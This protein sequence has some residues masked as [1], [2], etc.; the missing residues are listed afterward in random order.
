MELTGEWKHPEA[1]VECG[2]L[3]N[4]LENPEIRIF[5]C[6]TYLHYTDDHPSKP[7]DV[8]SGFSDYIEAHIPKSSFLDL[9]RDLSDN[10]SPYSFTLPKYQ[11]LAESFMQLGVG[12]P[13]H[14]ILYS[15]NGM[16]WATRIWWMLYVVGYPKV[17]VLNGGFAEWKRLSLPIEKSSCHFDRAN[18]K[19]N[20]NKEIFVGKTR[21]LQS[22]GDKSS[23]LL[24]ALTND[25]HTGKNPRYGRPGRIPNSLNIPFHDLIESNS[26]KL[27][28]PKETLKIF[29]DK[30]ISAQHEII[31]YC[32][33]GIAATLD[34]FVQ[35][36]LGMDKIQ[37]YDNSMSEWAMNEKLP[38]EI[39]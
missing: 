19:V 13:Y 39:G 1:I 16:Q 8:E 20:I 32:G 10:Q 25:L 37:I 35:W 15:R 18:F 12:E 23:I 2:W 22:M 3:K 26:D 14:I 7:Y 31:N 17:S 24:N 34:A 5:D 29:K 27:R 38:I 33:G 4:Q 6:T 36:Q 21:V 30:G 28:S 9:Q 11:D